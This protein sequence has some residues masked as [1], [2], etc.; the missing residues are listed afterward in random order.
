MRII[1]YITSLYNED[2][3][4]GDCLLI[5]QRFLHYKIEELIFSPWNYNLNRHLEVA[6]QVLGIACLIFPLMVS[7]PIG[8]VGILIKSISK[9]PPPVNFPPQRPYSIPY[10]IP[11]S[12]LHIVK[13][14]DN[15]D[16]KIF[17]E[18]HR[19]GDNESISKI[20]EILNDI[21]P[22]IARYLSCERI[23]KTMEVSKIFYLSAKHVNMH[24]ILSKYLKIE[25]FKIPGALERKYTKDFEFLGENPIGNPLTQI[26]L[27][28]KYNK[29]DSELFG[30]IAKN[31]KGGPIAFDK[32]EDKEFYPEDNNYI[33][34][35]VFRGKDESGNLYFALRLFNGDEKKGE[36]LLFIR[37]VN[38][39]WIQ[40]KNKYFERNILK[41]DDHKS[42]GY[43]LALIDGADLENRGGIEHPKFI[44]TLR[45]G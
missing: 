7:Y 45:I 30:H 38:K 20:Y 42:L 21:L 14:F 28:Q 24:P 6:L 26:K 19:S 11:H 27:Y 33:K 32:F 25:P 18:L 36:S 4:R 31:M 12:F 29:I 41:V 2:N 16:R 34:S 15:S 3:R 43:I 9:M 1:H 17:Q 44:K 39:V 10:Q 37:G 22:L 5:P 40:Q 13:R 23:L 8:F 35:P